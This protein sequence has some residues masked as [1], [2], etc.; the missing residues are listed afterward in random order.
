MY[1]VR[2]RFATKTLLKQVMIKHQLLNNKLNRMKLALK[3]SV[4]C[5]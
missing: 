4:F 1:P 2:N 3:R 5:F